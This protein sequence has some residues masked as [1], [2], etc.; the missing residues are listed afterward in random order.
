MGSATPAY[1][2]RFCPSTEGRQILPD[3]LQDTYGFKSFTCLHRYDRAL[4]TIVSYDAVL[5]LAGYP[6]DDEVRTRIMNTAQNLLA[7][8]DR[9]GLRS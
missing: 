6:V 5:M 2:V 9:L 3:I 4:G 1:P 7:E 8:R